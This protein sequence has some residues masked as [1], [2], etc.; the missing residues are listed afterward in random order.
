MPRGNCRRHDAF[1]VPIRKRKIE[2]S[3]IL[4][5]FEGVE[6]HHKVFV[7]RNRSGEEFIEIEEDWRSTNSGRQRDVSCTT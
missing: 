7:G 3:F 2:E 6:V 1:T 5:L 4:L